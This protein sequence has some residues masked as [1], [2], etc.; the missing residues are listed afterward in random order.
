[1]VAGTCRHP[2]S[3]QGAFR[4][5]LPNR[6]ESPPSVFR[7]YSLPS[8]IKPSP[9]KCGYGPDVFSAAHW[10]SRSVLGC[11]RFQELLDPLF[12]PLAFA[13]ATAAQQV[14]KRQKLIEPLIFLRGGGHATVKG[15]HAKAPDAASSVRPN[16][17]GAHRPQ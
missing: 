14:G 16:R 5:K 7:P 1:M 13:G 12:G 15:D 17:R 2:N 10:I 6:F 4:D 3:V 9:C 11:R 8:P